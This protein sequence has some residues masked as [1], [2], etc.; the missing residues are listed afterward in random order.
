LLNLTKLG[1]KLNQITE[2]KPILSVLN[3]NNLGSSLS[4][5]TRRKKTTKS[6]FKRPVL[7][8]SKKVMMEMPSANMLTAF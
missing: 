3:Y 7:P 8:I 6:E 4:K 2:P 1:L 5:L